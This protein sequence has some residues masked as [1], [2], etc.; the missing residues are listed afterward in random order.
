MHPAISSR[1]WLISLLSIRM[2][3]SVL[4]FCIR[5]TDSIRYIDPHSSLVS[6]KHYPSIQIN[7]TEALRV[8]KP[9]W[10][11]DGNTMNGGSLSSQYVSACEY[12]LPS[13]TYFMISDDPLYRP[14]VSPQSR[15]S[16][17]SQRPPR[18]RCIHSERTG[19]QQSHVPELFHDR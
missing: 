13:K 16:I 12:T 14:Y 5:H 10:M 1:R 2:P 6:S 19:K 4:S 11:K 15:T 9:A 17:Q 8:P 18:R 7:L 3:R